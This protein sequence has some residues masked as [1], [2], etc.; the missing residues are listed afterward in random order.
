MEGGALGG[1]MG[2]GSGSAREPGCPP[3]QYYLWYVVWY[4][5]WMVLYPHLARGASASFG[6]D[7]DKLASV[8]PTG[9]QVVGLGRMPSSAPAAVRGTSCCPAGGD[10]IV[11]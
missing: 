8:R 4:V 3:L 1:C 7:P 10:G 2:Y 6:W 9:P 11:W 5:V